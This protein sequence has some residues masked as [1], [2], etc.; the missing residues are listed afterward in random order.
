[1]SEVIGVEDVPPPQ[2]RSRPATRAEMPDAAVRLGKKARKNGFTVSATYSRGP[3]L[4]Q[5]WKVV[6]ISDCVVVRGWHED[7]RRFVAAWITKTGQRGKSAGVVKWDFE[8]GYRDGVVGRCTI[9]PI[10]AYLKPVSTT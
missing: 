4:D 8:L 1:M 9:Q 10:E 6:E 2:V 3:R 7:G 5:Y